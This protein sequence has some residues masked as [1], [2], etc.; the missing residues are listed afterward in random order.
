MT[1]IAECCT[2]WWCMP[3]NLEQVGL[4][5]S[6][7]NISEVHEN[8]FQQWQTGFENEAIL[9]GMP[10]HLDL[11]LVN[12]VSWLSLHLFVSMDRFQIFRDISS[13]LPNFWLPPN[14]GA[15][16]SPPDPIGSKLT[17]NV[18]CS[19][20]REGE[21][22]AKDRSTGLKL[23]QVWSFQSKLRPGWMPCLPESQSPREA[24]VPRCIN[25]GKSAPPAILPALHL[26]LHW[27]QSHNL[28]LIQADNL[29][30]TYFV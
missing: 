30:L 18:T 11:W 6:P 23:G 7:S 25:S 24:S 8:G 12:L 2:C 27:G 19:L 15:L 4:I 1:T 28:V 26:R 9:A 13:C 3:A 17:P 5:L 10:S 20:A 16:P 14:L 22:I 21:D 29:Q